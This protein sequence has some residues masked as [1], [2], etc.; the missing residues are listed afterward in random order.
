MI[1]A[2]RIDEQGTQLQHKAPSP[3]VE[4]QQWFQ[5]GTTSSRAKALAGCD[6]LNSID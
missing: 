4:N 5:A 3:K 2:A 6:G 1:S